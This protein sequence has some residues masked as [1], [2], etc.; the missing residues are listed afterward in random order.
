M[1]Y[2]YVAL[3]A[4]R[5]SKHTAKPNTPLTPVHLKEDG[6]DEERTNLTCRALTRRVASNV[7]LCQTSR[8]CARVSSLALAHGGA[9]EIGDA[10]VR[11]EGKSRSSVGVEWHYLFATCDMRAHCGV[12]LL[13]GGEPGSAGAHSS[14]PTGSPVAAKAWLASAAKP[15]WP[16]NAFQPLCLRSTCTC[17][18]GTTCTA[19]WAEAH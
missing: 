14:A 6:R 3:E 11:N 13:G 2:K 1:F 17:Q 10:G 7:L 16:Q 19:T 4:R 5:E 12:F 18:D 15:A 8:S 9:A